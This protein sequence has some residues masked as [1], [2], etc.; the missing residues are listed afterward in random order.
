MNRGVI[1]IAVVQLE[2]AQIFQRAVQLR[3]QILPF[4]HPQVGEKVRLAEF[5]PLALRAE[6]L[7]L[8]VNR[9]P[10]FQQREKIR[11]RIGKAF[12][13]GGGG[14]F[15]VERPFARILNAQAGGDD[16][17]FARGV[18][19]LRLQQHPAQ[20]RINRQPREIVAELRQLARCRRARQ[21]PASSW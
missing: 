20:R 15:V 13:R 5:P 16:E 8:V 10:D 11:L 14:V 18:F 19:V 3:V 1:G 7:P 12:V 21:V 17:Q 6:P 9:V 4:A 2:A